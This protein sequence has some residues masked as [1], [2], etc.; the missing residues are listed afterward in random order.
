MVQAFA[1]DALALRRWDD[2]A[3]NPAATPPDWAHYLRVLKS[4]AGVKN[5][6]A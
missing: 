5:A 3:K 1:T 2:C 4:A 6:A